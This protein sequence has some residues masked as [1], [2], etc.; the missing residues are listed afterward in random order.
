MITALS[1]LLWFLTQH[2]LPKFFSA[3]VLAGLVSWWRRFPGYAI[4]VFPLAM[5]DVFPATSS[6]VPSS[7]RRARTV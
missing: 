4:M 5:L 2:P 3:M 1:A 7:T 6:A